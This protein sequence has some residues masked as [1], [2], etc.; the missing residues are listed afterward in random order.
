MASTLS[1]MRR[2]AFASPS[3]L[4]HAP[5]RFRQPS[6]T[7]MLRQSAF[8]T[9][10]SGKER[11]SSS[12]SL[13]SP[14][15]AEKGLTDRFPPAQ[16]KKYT[17]DHEWVNLPSSSK[18]A[19]LGISAYAAHAL[20]DVVYVE[21]PTLAESFSA[22]DTIA[23]VESVKSASDIKTPVSGT[24]VEVNGLLERSPAVMGTK[25]E[26]NGAEG[27]WLTRIEL[28]EDGLRDMEGLMGE[29]EYEAFISE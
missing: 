29:E 3:A 13:F 6:F 9:T 10:S 25:P 27:G 15:A 21:L 28:S 12:A 18:V 22:G 7:F 2:V 23:A 16:Q 26:D 5:A 19:T 14:V 24:L 4:R 17:Q 8:S 20:G 1:A 11:N